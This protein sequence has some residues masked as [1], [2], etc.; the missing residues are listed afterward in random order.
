[1]ADDPTP[2]RFVEEYT[3]PTPPCW[4][5]THKSTLGPTC[6]AF[7]RGIPQEILSGRHQHRVAYPGDRG[8]RYQPD[9]AE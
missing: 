1:M 7:P 6:A 8:I 5:C 2:N 3:Q 4:T 9:E